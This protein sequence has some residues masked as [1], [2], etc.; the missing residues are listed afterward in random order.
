[1]FTLTVSQL[2]RYVKALVE[3]DSKLRDVYIKGEISNFI[4]HYRSGHFYFTLKDEKSAVKAVMFKSYAS[5]LPFEPE[6]GMLVLARASVGVFERDGVYQLYITDLQPDGAGALAVAYEQLKR[7]L[8]AEGLFDDGRKKPLPAYPKTIGVVTSETGAAFQ[9]IVNVLTRRWPLAKVLLAPAQVQGQGAADTLVKGLRALDR[10]CD[11]IIIGRGGG[12]A[13]DLWQFN[14]EALA[15]QIG[16]TE[17]PVVSAVGHETDFTICDLAADVRAPT[18]SAAAELA[19]PSMDDL[20]ERV[21]ACDE[22]LR[23]SAWNLVDGQGL[24]RVNAYSIWLRRNAY[25]L[26]D[27]L[28]LELD[29]LTSAAALR[30]PMEQIKKKQEKLDFL[31][32]MLYNNKKHILE[33]HS[34]E[35]SRRAALLDSLSPLRVLERGYAAVYRED[36]PLASVVG[37][38]PGDTVDMRLRDG[39][40]RA[41]AEAVVKDKEVLINKFYNGI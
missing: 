27:R 21:A 22:L 18:P 24:K 25:G 30:S 12:S 37:V 34:R 32:D 20:R 14:S 3:E 1:M 31:C 41:T 29:R 6:S 4:N 28:G 23:Q 35:L 39:K 10:R 19:T 13:E 36:K 7:K 11:V 17:T 8:S 15:R 40:I 33:R 9:D 38:K 5:A 26:V 16:V 2:N